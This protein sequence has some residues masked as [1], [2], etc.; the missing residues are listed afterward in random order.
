MSIR[1]DKNQIGGITVDDDNRLNP[2]SSFTHFDNTTIPAGKAFIYPTTWWINQINFE[3]HIGKKMM[4]DKAGIAI[5]KPA[6][7]V[8]ES[9][10]G[11]TLIVAILNGDFTSRHDFGKITY[12]Y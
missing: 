2:I 8:V 11:A 7:A 5:Q 10:D 4:F 1:G 9:W 3:E 6:F 12:S